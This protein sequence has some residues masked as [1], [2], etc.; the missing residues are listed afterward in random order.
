MAIELRHFVDLLDA[1]LA[2][3]TIVG[4]AAANIAWRDKT[5]VPVKGVPYLKPEPAARQRTPMGIGADAVQQW[6]GA[7]Q[8]GV[9]TPRESGGH[10]RDAIASQLLALFPRGLSMQTAQGLW[11]TVIRGTAPESVPF[12]DWI[13]LPVTISW[14]AHEPPP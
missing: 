11:M 3:A 12:G 8:I 1:R 10:L 7:Y 4:I 6:D 5:Y 2:G 14:F 9:M 13:N